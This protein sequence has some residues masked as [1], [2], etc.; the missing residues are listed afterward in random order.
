M[1]EA[2]QLLQVIFKDAQLVQF[3]KSVPA[4]QDADVGTFAVEDGHQADSQVQ[5]LHLVLAAQI[6]FDPTVLRQTALRD[7]HVGHDL[8]LAGHL[9]LLDGAR[10]VEVRRKLQVV[11]HAVDAQAHAAGALGLGVEVDVAGLLPRAEQDG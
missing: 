8:E 4:A 5:V 2:A 9:L 7:V 6:D 3:E 1:G 10:V 11:Q